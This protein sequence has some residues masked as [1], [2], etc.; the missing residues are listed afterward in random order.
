MSTDLYDIANRTYDIP[1]KL[2]AWSRTIIIG[3]CIRT[4]GKKYAYFP[5]DMRLSI[6]VQD[7]EFIGHG[8][9]RNTKWEEDSKRMSSYRIED[10]TL[11]TPDYLDKWGRNLM[12]EFSTRVPDFEPSIRDKFLFDYCNIKP[13]LPLVSSISGLVSTPMLMKS[14][15]ACRSYYSNGE[16]GTLA[17][18]HTPSR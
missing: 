16:S 15:Q 1:L 11:P 5:I 6:D 3:H 12:G 8:F 7:C 4:G 9:G 18:R 13:L 14:A 10:S 17:S 2:D